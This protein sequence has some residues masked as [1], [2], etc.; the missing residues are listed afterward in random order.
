MPRSTGKVLLGQPTLRPRLAAASHPMRPRTFATVWASQRPPRAVAIPRA[1][2][3]AAIS[4]NDFAPALCASR[5]AGASVTANTSA[6]ACERHLRLRGPRPG[7]D[8]RDGCREPLPPP[9][10][11]SCECAKLR[12]A[13][14]RACAWCFR[15]ASG[16]RRLINLDLRG[17][18]NVVEFQ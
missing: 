3:A 10:L 13:R 12:T 15:Y 5:M 18:L 11:P 4:R 17:S 7:V 2:K 9:D 1:F 8:F 6:L 14:P 16:L